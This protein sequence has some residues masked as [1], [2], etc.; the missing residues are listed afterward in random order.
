MKNRTVALLEARVGAQMADLVR[1]YGGTPFSAPAL[2]E[3]PDVDP[4]HIASLIRA[5]KSNPPEFFIF[6]TGVGTKALFATTDT[7]GLT[8]A[9]KALLDAAVVVVRGPKPTAALRARGVRID[10]AA[11]E[12]FTTVEVLAELDLATLRGR[13]VVVQRYGETN[14]DLRDA[15]E[16]GG[17]ETTEIATYRWGLPANC[18]PLVALVDALERNA[19]D[20]VA[21]TSASQVH[22]LFT[23]ARDSGRLAALESGLAR[24]MVASIGP[25]CSAAL[26]GHGVAVALEAHPPKLGPFMT[27]INDALAALPARG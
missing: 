12:P 2:S 24:T 22:N 18:E 21:F 13:R 14:R 9:F 23:I 25:V 20:V 17:A 26:A 5:W 4:A 8:D 11:V 3:I 10:R 1:K 16:A 6:Q 27:A 7:L 19:I 15:L